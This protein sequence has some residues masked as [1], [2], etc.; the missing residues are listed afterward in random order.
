MSAYTSMRPKESNPE[1]RLSVI[2]QGCV[3]VGVMVVCYVTGYYVMPFPVPALSTP[4]ARLLYTLQWQVVPAYL[5]FA[6]IATVALTRFFTPAIN[7]LNCGND[8]IVTVHV[9]YVQNTLEQFVLSAVGQLMIS[10]YLDDRQ[11]KVIP[12]FVFLFV[13][14]RITFWIGYTRSY[15]QRLFGMILTVV[16]TMLLYVVLLHYFFMYGP[17]SMLWR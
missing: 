17:M 5:L 8:H 9:R 7:P 12:V 14:G 4:I 11:M 10:M 1:E 13:V 15:I 16:P 6:G 2:K 3:S